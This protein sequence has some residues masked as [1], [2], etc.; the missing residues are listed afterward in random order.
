MATENSEPQDPLIG[1]KFGG[2]YEVRRR[3]GEGGM[4]VVYAGHDAMLQR[5]V[6]IKILREDAA[7]RGIA[8]QRLQREAR[9][10][11]QLHHRH[12]ITFHD[13]GMHDDRVFIV[14]E[15]LRGL[16]LA[17]VAGTDNGP[18]SALRA[19]GIGAQ[20]C[21]ALSVVHG[22]GI[23]HRDLKP[24][25]VFLIDKG[26]TTD[27]VKLLD[28]SIAKLPEEL[29]DGRLTQTGA[30]FGTPR[31]MAPEQ[32]IG[33]PAVFQTD[34]YS[35]GAMLFEMV[36]GRSPFV[37]D[38]AIKLL[39]MQN[40]HAAPGLAEVGATA[41]QP[42]IDLVAALL[43]REPWRRPRTADEVRVQLE[44][45]VAAG[46]AGEAPAPRGRDKRRLAGIADRT[47]Q[48]QDGG[49]RAAPVRSPSAVYRQFTATGSPVS[50]G[51]VER[52]STKRPSA[53]PPARP[54]RRATVPRA[55]IASRSPSSSHPRASDAASAQDDLPD[56][57]M[58]D[59]PTADDDG[60]D[61]QAVTQ[62]RSTLRRRS[63]ETIPRWTTGRK[64]PRDKPD[65]D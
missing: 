58:A 53:P 2:R 20:I 25:N 24:D 61:P 63:R 23:V 8:S 36:A 38:N 59:S 39:T 56:G 47:Q 22:A 31:Y 45:I 65:P 50:S 33:D 16:P 30:V 54:Q 52:S 42:F 32:A 5:D 11:G 7:Q 15:L 57:H 18:M 49:D 35:L 21:S 26:D 3:L 14:M 12:I 28:F 48:G 10:A 27:F 43:E 34:L 44:Q 55:A 17:D 62:P 4:A 29:V 37:A 60:P 46:D 51:E 9:A 19:A 13:V 6:A 64:V 41:P 40:L 1:T